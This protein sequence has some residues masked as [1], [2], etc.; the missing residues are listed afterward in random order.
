MPNPFP[1][2]FKFSLLMALAALAGCNKNDAKPDPKPVER[3][4]KGR[5]LQGVSNTP[6]ADIKIIITGCGRNGPGPSGPN[7]PEIASG[8][9]KVDG[10][11]T[12]P[13]VLEDT[14]RVPT[15]RVE[16]SDSIQGPGYVVFLNQT[17]INNVSLFAFKRWLRPVR[18]IVNKNE[19][20]LLLVRYGEDPVRELT[21]RRGSVDTTISMWGTGRGKTLWVAAPDA[22]AGKF[23]GYSFGVQF[24]Q[25]DTMRAEIG[26]IMQMPFLP[27]Y[28]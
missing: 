17:D 9:T 28:L 27:D 15:L 6:L 25:P 5:L 16:E 10:T 8:F 12:I 3:I 22:V 18:I 4:V 19:S 7:C 1:F 21:F 26:D 13:F 24:S 23:R 14:T 11:F 2:T 20:N